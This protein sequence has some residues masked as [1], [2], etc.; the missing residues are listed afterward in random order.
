M[1]KKRLELVGTDGINPKMTM[2]PKIANK[3]AN[4]QS[5]KPTM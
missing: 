2:N 5:A 4:M 3:T 1:P